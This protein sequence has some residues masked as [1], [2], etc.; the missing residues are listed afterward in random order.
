MAFSICIG[1]VIIKVVSY[2]ALGVGD[3]NRFSFISKDEFNFRDKEFIL[4]FFFYFLPLVSVPSIAVAWIRGLMLAERP[5]AIHLRFGLRELKFICWTFVFFVF[6]IILSIIFAIIYSILIQVIS[7]GIHFY[8]F[9]IQLPLFF[10]FAL[11]ALSLMA[12]IGLVLPAMACDER[13]PLSKA[14]DTVWSLG[15][16]MVL[17]AI[18]AVFPVVVLLGLFVFLFG[19]PESGYPGGALGLVVVEVINLFALILAIGILTGGYYILRERQMSSGGG[20]Q[21]PQS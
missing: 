18:I 15:A 8:A 14:F 10:I 7:G 19:L 2:F 6:F 9:F 16:P 11:I 17:A 13:V 21:V 12:S 4:L 1:W 20:P 5:W 3:I